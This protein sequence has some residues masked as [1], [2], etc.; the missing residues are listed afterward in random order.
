MN[1]AIIESLLRTCQQAREIIGISDGSQFAPVR[2]APEVYGELC[3]VVT[4][5]GPHGLQDGGRAV[6]ATPTPKLTSIALH[7]LRIASSSMFPYARPC[8]DDGCACRGRGTIRVWGVVG[9][10]QITEHLMPGNARA[11]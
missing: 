2:V 5:G 1:E 7:G 4:A 6:S 10:K 9:M 11:E 3:H 8:D